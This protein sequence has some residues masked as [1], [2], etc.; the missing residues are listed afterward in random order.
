MDFVHEEMYVLFR[1]LMLLCVN[2]LNVFIYSLENA[3]F[4]CLC[5]VLLIIVKAK[6]SR[7]KNIPH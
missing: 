4:S 6:C 3:L 2:A 5:K 7:H 1:Y